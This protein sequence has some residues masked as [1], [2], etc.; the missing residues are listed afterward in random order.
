[1]RSAPGLLS[2]F[3][4]AMLS[5]SNLFVFKGTYFSLGDMYRDDKYFGGVSLG[6]MENIANYIKNNSESEKRFS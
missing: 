1:M 2:I 3:L 4:I 5:A 6:E